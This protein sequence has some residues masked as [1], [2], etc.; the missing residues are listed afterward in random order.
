MVKFTYIFILIFCL[1]SCLGTKKTTEKKFQSISTEKVSKSIDSTNNTTVN[2][3][4]SDKITVEVPVSDPIVDAKIDEILRKLNVEKSSGDNKYKIYYDK[5]LRELRAEFI[6]GETR[7]KETKTS[8]EVVSEKAFEQTVTEN[9]KKVIKI[10]P[11]YLWLV[12][13]WLTRKI[14]LI[15]IISIF[16]PG[17][18]GINTIQDL[19]NPP[20]N[21]KK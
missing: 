9:T 4:I 21:N 5:K 10:I 2:K 6:V 16:I 8:N 19:L 11:W 18:K 3:Q 15:P 1:S 13:I 7:N 14:F 20:N 17:I 12:L